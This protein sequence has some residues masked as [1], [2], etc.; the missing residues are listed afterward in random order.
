MANIDSAFGFKLVST[1]MENPIIT[2]Y[3]TDTQNLFRGDLVELIASVESASFIDG[4]APGHPAVE[5]LNGETDT[6]YGVMLQKHFTDPDADHSIQYAV[7]GTPCLVDVCIDPNAIYEV[8][9]DEGFA[10]TNTSQN[11]IPTLGAGNTATGYSGM[12]LDSSTLATANT[13]TLKVLGLARTPGNSL[14]TNAKV[15]VKLNLSQAGASVAG[16]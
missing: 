16:V 9:C 3:F 2:C 13:L 12:E 6:P 10:Y 1:S 15:L 7:G 14:G 5:R 8:Q 11:A 4:V